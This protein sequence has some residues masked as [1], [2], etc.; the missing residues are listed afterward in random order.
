MT[1]NETLRVRVQFLFALRILFSVSNCSVIES[2]GE[3]AKSPEPPTEQKIQPLVSKR[4]SRLGQLSP[5]F[6]AIRY[7]FS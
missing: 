6:N 3:A 2:V 4:P 7:T 1:P 5:A